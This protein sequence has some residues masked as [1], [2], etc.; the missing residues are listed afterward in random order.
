[1]SRL[2]WSAFGL[3]ARIVGAVLIT[4]VATL[5]VAALTLLPR[6]EGSLRGASMTTLKT[7]VRS[8]EQEIA[9]LGTLSYAYI[10]AFGSPQLRPFARAEAR[11]LGQAETRL[12]NQ[13]G[14]TV[15]LI[16]FVDPQGHGRP[17]LLPGQ[18]ADSLPGGSLSDITPAFTSGKPSYSFGTIG[19]TQYVRTAIPFRGADAVLAIRKAIDQIPSAVRAVQNAFALAA[20]AGLVLTLVLAIPL[21]G[22]LVGRLQR[23]REA[24]LRVAVEG[25][26]AEF[27]VDRARDEVGDL[28]RSFA[29]MQR[30]LRGQEEARRAFVATASHELRTPL[31]SLYGM[32]ELIADELGDEH[33]DLADVGE[34]VDRARAQ[35]RRLARLAAD[36]LDL[37]RIDAEVPL[38]SEPVELGELS[39]AVLAE[40]EL[41]SVERGIRTGLHEASEPVWALADPGSVARILRILL[42]NAM[43]VAPTGSAVSVELSDR[44]VPT[45]TVS[46]EGP[47]VAPEERE[48]IF[49]RFTRGRDTGGQAG[50]GLG[51]AIG[52][53]LA[54]RMGGELS[55]RPE[56]GPGATFALTLRRATAPVEEPQG[57]TT[58]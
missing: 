47:G 58:S 4:A 35:S 20:L 28:A 19:S 12:A 1:V 36:L 3:R 10:Q 31:T 46:D 16:G 27:P 26:G 54:G 50:F 41:A 15:T 18:D 39:R 42:D 40:F 43:R 29:I 17:V 21:A 56:S 53:E 8:H 14:A 45:L 25:T 57:V 44:P 55:L 49:E 33:P 5:V 51:L 23:L 24:A 2:R 6:L 34:M 7:D 22:T 52:R 32:L 13:T 9:R 30:R 11:A 48:A 37:S 38:R